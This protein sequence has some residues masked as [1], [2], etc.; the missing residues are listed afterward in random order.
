MKIPRITYQIFSFLEKIENNRKYVAPDLHSDF[1][2]ITLLQ[3][4]NILFKSYRRFVFSLILSNRYNIVK[5]NFRL[6]NSRDSC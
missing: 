4:D 3:N 6:I 5:K 1:K 2:N